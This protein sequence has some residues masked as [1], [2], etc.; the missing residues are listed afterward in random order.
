MN[1]PECLHEGE[2]LNH[3]GP[4]H[5]TELL[6]NSV[7]GSAHVLVGPLPEKHVGVA[8]GQ[9]KSEQTKSKILGP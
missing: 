2:L 9:A 4:D 6:Q 7:N 8:G 5:A 1:L 3:L